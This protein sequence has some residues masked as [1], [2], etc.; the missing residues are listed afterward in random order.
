MFLSSLI[1]MVL[2]LTTKLTG[3]L[4]GPNTKGKEIYCTVYQRYS[5]PAFQSRAVLL[6][7]NTPMKCLLQIAVNNAF[8]FYYTVEIRE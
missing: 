5:S 4:G 2:E 6:L 3:I 8:L 1:G 7:G